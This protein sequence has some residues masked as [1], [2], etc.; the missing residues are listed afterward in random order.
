MGLDRVSCTLAVVKDEATVVLAN[1]DGATYWEFKSVAGLAINQDPLLKGKLRF[2]PTVSV[3]VIG[4]NNQKLHLP[5]N[6]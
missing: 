1:T 2:S 6:L 5:R 3:S 4:H